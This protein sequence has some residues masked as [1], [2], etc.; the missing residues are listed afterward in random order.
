MQSIQTFWKYFLFEGIVLFLLGVFALGSPQ[1]MTL[2]IEILI[3]SLLMIGG[4]VQFAR[5]Y[6]TEDSLKFVGYIGAI[7][8]FIAGALI[9]LHPIVATVTLTLLLAIYFFVEGAL[10]IVYALRYWSILRWS[11]LLLNGILSV[12]LG[13]LI[14]NGWP[15][16]SLWVLG[17]YVGIYFLFLGLAMIFMGL[18][19]H[20]IKS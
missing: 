19:L 14:W 3:G 1:I 5:T 16:N 15:N 13:L 17:L 20:K 2:S 12:I 10:R 4:I 7:I 11:G 6:K 9:I 8:T 18:K